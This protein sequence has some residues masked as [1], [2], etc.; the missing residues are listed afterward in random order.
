M[1]GLS[2]YIESDYWGL[3][4]CGWLRDACSPQIWM[5]FLKNFKQPLIEYMNIPTF[6]HWNIPTIENLNILR[7]EYLNK[8][9]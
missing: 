8:F 3:S 4:V 5:N 7:F 6:E 1:G 9:E 2:L